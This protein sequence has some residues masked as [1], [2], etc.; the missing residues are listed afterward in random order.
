MDLKPLLKEWRIWVLLIAIIAS[1]SLLSPT[2]TTN[3]QGE[4]VMETNLNRGLEIQGGVSVLVSIDKDNVTQEDAESIATI[5]QSRVSGLGLTQSEVQTVQIGDTWNI[6]VEAATNNPDQIEDVLTQEG[7]FEARMPINV[8]DSLTYELENSYTFERNNNTVNVNNTTYSPGENFT[9]EN[10]RFRYINNTEN[11]ANLEAV[12]YDGQDVSTVV[13]SDARVTSQGGQYRFEFPIVL[14]ADAADE[15]QRVFQNYAGPTGGRLQMP[16]GEPAL[17]KL[18]VDNELRN[19]LTVAASFA[20]SAVTRPYI[21]GSGETQEEARSNMRQLQAILSSGRLEYPVEVERNSTYSA[22]RGSQFMVAAF[23]S[24]IAAVAATG[25]LVHFR[26]RSLSTSIPIVITGSSEVLILLG[27]WFSTVATLNLA[28]IAGIIAAVGTGVDDQI[29]IKDES[30]KEALT[31]WRKK[32]KNAFFAIFTSAASTIGAMLP[33]INPT[34]V[35]VLVGVAGASILLY[36]AYKRS[37][38]LHMMG[39]GVAAVL[40]SFIISRVST[41]S[42]ALQDVRGFAVTTI[43]GILIGIAITRPAYAKILEHFESN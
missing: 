36:M 39:I 32:I 41:S 10:T 7:S 22:Q 17:Q 40:V 38:N 12:A 37:R 21:T 23:A 20:D 28:S 9:L 30:E 3:E 42:Y 15:A 34:Q 19:S 4:P 5:L 35:N 13:N 25:A 43:V 27:A 33:L 26:Y 31:D 8:Y 1:V 29:I 18:Y 6:Q 2:T 14:N 24:I 16:N 11:Y